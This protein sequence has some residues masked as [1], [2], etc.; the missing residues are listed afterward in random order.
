MIQFSLSHSIHWRKHLEFIELL[1]AAFPNV[2]LTTDTVDKPLTCAEF[3]AHIREGIPSAYHADRMPLALTLDTTLGKLADFLEH[4]IREDADHS[5]IVFCDS[6][7]QWKRIHLPEFAV[8][9]RALSVMVSP[10]ISA[11]ELVAL[12]NKQEPN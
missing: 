8:M 4:V 7:P 1:A 12:Q 3:I 2:V 6:F 11:E 5:I 10:T 9:V